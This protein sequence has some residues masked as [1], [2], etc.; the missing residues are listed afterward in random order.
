MDLYLKTTYLAVY[1]PHNEVTL[2]F[3]KFK[4]PQHTDK[5][6][7]IPHI[8]NCDRKLADRDLRTE[9]T[10]SLPVTEQ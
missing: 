10:V 8:I 5:C 9:E 2:I 4:S 7:S 6:K 1:F 3:L